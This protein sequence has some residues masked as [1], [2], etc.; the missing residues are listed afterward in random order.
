MLSLF[1]KKQE[2]DQVKILIVD[3]EPDLIDTIQCRLEVNNYQVCTASNGEEGLSK[4]A[5]EKPDLILLDTNMPVMNGWEF[6]ERYSD[7]ANNMKA[8][9]LLVLLS[10]TDDADRLGEINSCPEIH[11]TVQKPLSRKKLQDVIDSQL[12][13]VESRDLLDVVDFLFGRTEGVPAHVV[14]E[15]ENFPGK[16]GLLPGD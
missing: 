6:I 8:D 16:I 9:V 15:I 5:D 1:K 4:A 13:Q 14:N 7:I 3:D 11:G 2:T 12:I 10:G